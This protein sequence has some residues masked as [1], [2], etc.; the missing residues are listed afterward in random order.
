MKYIVTESQ[1]KRIIKEDRFVQLQNASNT[2]EKIIN[3]F[4]SIDC[5]DEMSLYKY[6]YVKTFC[7]QL[8]NRSLDE[9]IQMRDM[10]EQ[11]LSTMVNQ[12]FRSKIG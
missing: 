6:N 11:E 3:N 8:R 10:M 7:Q 4:D 12:E 2:L 5:A 1:L 9:L